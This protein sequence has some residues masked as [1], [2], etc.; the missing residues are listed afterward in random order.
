MMGKLLNTADGLVRTN[1]KVILSA[2]I[3]HLE[4]VDSALT[5]PGR[6]FDVLRFRELTVKEAAAAA[7][8]AGIEPPTCSSTLATLFKGPKAHVATTPRVGFGVSS[9]VRAV[10]A[11]G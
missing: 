11:N 5:R 8:A 2:N 1:K 9:K 10:A 3:T 7:L 4:N 6:C